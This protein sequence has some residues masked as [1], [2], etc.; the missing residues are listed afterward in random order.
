VRVRAARAAERSPIRTLNLRRN[1]G[2]HHD[3]ITTDK[4][5]CA[6]EPSVCPE[7]M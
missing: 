5:A 4:L 1:G 7:R 3:I 6:G 2:G